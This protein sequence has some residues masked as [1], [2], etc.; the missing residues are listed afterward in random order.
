RP[1][2]GPSGGEGAMSA[3][4]LEG[5]DHVELWVGNARQAAHFFA[6]GLGFEVVAYAG[7]ETG[8]PD[9][10]SYVLEQGALRL[11]VTGALRAA[12]PIAAHHRA[13][14]DGV[15]SLAFAVTDA[16]AAYDTALSRGP[17]G[18]AGP[19]TDE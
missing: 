15:R 3:V 12:S 2:Q 4:E 13:H 9:R 7:P 11:V 6:S 16:A 10:A 8:V 1:G 14:G 5:W 19:R 18:I 17:V